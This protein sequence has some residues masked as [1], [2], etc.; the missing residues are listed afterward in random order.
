MKTRPPPFA[1]C[2]WSSHGPLLDNGQET[3]LQITPHVGLHPGVQRLAKQPREGSIDCLQTGTP[4]S[5]QDTN[6]LRVVG[7][8]SFH[9]LVEA[10]GEVYVLRHGQ[11]EQSVLKVPTALGPDC[12]MK[13]L[14]MCSVVRLR[15]SSNVAPWVLR[16]YEGEGFLIRPPLA[17]SGSVQGCD[18]LLNLLWRRRGLA[19]SEHG[20]VDELQ[21]AAHLRLY[22]I[23]QRRPEHRLVLLLNF[24]QF[25]GRACAQNL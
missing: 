24:Q 25:S 10:S 7:A 5:E 3:A 23:D 1:T 4:L 12:L 6:K 19:R 2:G 17:L 21:E 9:R 13:V 16:Q 22:V 15:H 18:V 8:C 20:H 14:A 11:G